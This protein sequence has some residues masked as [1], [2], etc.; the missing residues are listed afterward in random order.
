MPYTAK[1]DEMSARTVTK[2]AQNPPKT[3]CLTPKTRTSPK[4]KPTSTCTVLKET[5]IM[6]LSRVKRVLERFDHKRGLVFMEETRRGE[7][8]G[9]HAS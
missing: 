2:R 9:V 5:I 7:S 3:T 6:E 8:T 1:Y 4:A